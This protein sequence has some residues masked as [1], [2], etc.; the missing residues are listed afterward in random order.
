MLAIYNNSASTGG[1]AGTKATHGTTLALALMEM[2]EDQSINQ[3]L[4][5]VKRII[6]YMNVI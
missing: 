4:I 3:S 6:N 2:E 1:T 5:M